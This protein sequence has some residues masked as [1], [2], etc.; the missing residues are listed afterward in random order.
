M[1]KTEIIAQQIRDMLADAAKNRTFQGAAHRVDI[2]NILR[3]NE[4]YFIGISIKDNRNK[5][6]E[7]L[8]TL[9][10]VGN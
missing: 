1:T 8:L 6:E 5:T 4:G 3:T 2:T 7:Y 9:R 10:Y